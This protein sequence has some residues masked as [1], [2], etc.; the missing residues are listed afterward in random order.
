MSMNLQ[1]REWSNVKKDVKTT[2]RSLFHL[3]GCVHPRTDWELRG[4]TLR[5]QEN[6]R[7]W[8]KPVSIMTYDSYDNFP[9]T[10]ARGPRIQPLQLGVH[11]A[12]ARG[13]GRDGSERHVLQ[14]LQLHQ[15]RERKEYAINVTTMNLVFITIS[16]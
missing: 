14:A 10:S 7:R 8:G 12:E 2:I 11:Q 16:L 6:L 3:P 9:Y 15:R 4:R 5:S 1:T 13:Q